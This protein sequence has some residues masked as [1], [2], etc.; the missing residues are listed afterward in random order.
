MNIFLVYKGKK[1]NSELI[2]H[3]YNQ[4]HIIQEISLMNTSLDDIHACNAD[5]ILFDV[6]SHKGESND[7]L[8]LEKIQELT[9]KIPILLVTHSSETALYRES[10][11]NGGV[12]GSIQFPFLEEELFLRLEKLV[13]KKDS[14][15]FKG[16]TIHTHDISMNMYSHVVEKK[17][18]K[19]SLTKT[20]YRI[21]LHLFLHK[22]VPVPSV[23]L[24][25]CLVENSKEVPLSLSVHIFNLRKKIQD[26]TL[27]KT[28]PLYGFTVSD[29]YTV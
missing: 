21:L 8:L 2:V 25:G 26:L 22:N 1:A 7:L 15:L 16:T 18:E 27:I 9:K 29:A 19:L 14:L 28:V 4:I 3:L 23:S 24:S 12:D 13:R 11:I 17:G 10:M 20:E 6:S 5:V